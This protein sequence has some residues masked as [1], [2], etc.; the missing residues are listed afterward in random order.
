MQ[1]LL[2]KEENHARWNIDESFQYQSFICEAEKILRP[3]G[4]GAS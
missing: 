1:N 2:A 3:L 4:R